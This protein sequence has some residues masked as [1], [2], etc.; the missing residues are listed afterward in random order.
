MISPYDHADNRA[1]FHYEGPSSFDIDGFLAVTADGGWHFTDQFV[2]P[3]NHFY[4]ASETGTYEFTGF[5]GQLTTYNL[6]TIYIDSYYRE[7]Y[8]GERSSGAISP[9]SI[10][11]INISARAPAKDYIEEAMLTLYWNWYTY[12]CSILFSN[13]TTSYS[14]GVAELNLTTI[15]CPE[16]AFAVGVDVHDDRIPYIDSISVTDEDGNT[17]IMTE[18]LCVNESSIIVDFTTVW[19]ETTLEIYNLDFNSTCFVSTGPFTLRY[20]H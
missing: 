17:H 2:V 19:S 3:Q 12:R 10:E 18:T 7:Y 4:W 6:M 5:S 9:A 16:Y 14:C 15:N 11:Y 13:I 8:L 20:L 1:I